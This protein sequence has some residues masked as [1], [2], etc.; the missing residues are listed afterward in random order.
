VRSRSTDERQK[1]AL[2]AEAEEETQAERSRSRRYWF[3][4]NWQGIRTRRS[5]DT[6][7]RET[8]LIKLDTEVAAIRAGE[9]PKTF[10]PITVQAM[11]DAWILKVETDCK[12]RTQID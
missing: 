9:L 10:E 5:L 1:P 12:E 11:F 4:L 2:D 8:A 7:D 6:T 3:E